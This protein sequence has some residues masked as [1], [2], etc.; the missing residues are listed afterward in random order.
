[1]QKGAFSVLM[2]VVLLAGAMVV[3]HVR[4]SSGAAKT[5]S[6]LSSRDRRAGEAQPP[7]VDTDGIAVYF[8]PQGGCEAAIVDQIDH[9]QRSIDMQAYSFT[10][11]PIAKALG[12]AEGRG[13][14]VRAVLDKVATGEHY[15]GAT[16]LKD[17]GISTFTDGDH[18]IAHNKVMIIDNATVITGSFN[19]T[20]QAE[21]ANAE[22]LLIIRGK[23]A[24]AGAYERNFDEHLGHSEVYTG[25]ITGSTGERGDR[26]Q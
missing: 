3:D 17:H 26:E 19:F 23:P 18:P 21:A 14:R 10:S 16:Y 12:E 4:Q 15:T 20:H 11:V 6:A 9:A 25:V 24:L 5:D 8:S 7:A 1:M 2:F 22:N 13:V